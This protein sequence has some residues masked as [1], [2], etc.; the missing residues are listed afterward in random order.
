[1]HNWACMETDL[2]LPIPWSRTASSAWAV[3]GW[4]APARICDGKI[5]MSLMAC[6]RICDGM[7]GVDK[8]FRACEQEWGHELL[9]Q[10]VRRFWAGSLCVTRWL[11]WKNGA[12]LNLARSCSSEAFWLHIPLTMYIDDDLA[13]VLVNLRRLHGTGC[14]AYITCSSI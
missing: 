14:N 12:F 7:L 11:F 1:M 10:N 2:A 9:N 8:R 4:A 13:L 5:L 3:G 6:L